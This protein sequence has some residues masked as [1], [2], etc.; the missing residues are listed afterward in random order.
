[1]FATLSIAMAAAYLGHIQFCIVPKWVKERRN[2]QKS[3]RFRKDSITFSIFSINF[4][5]AWQVSFTYIDLC[6]FL[7]LYPWS[8]NHISVSHLPND[9]FIARWPFYY[10]T[11][12]NARQIQCYI[13]PFLQRRPHLLTDA[14]LHC[15][16]TVTLSPFADRCTATLH[17]RRIAVHLR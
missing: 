8:T 10:D 15:I 2:K 11:I 17:F 4:T 1:M 16:S 3:E 7:Q 5:S 14:T 13:A 12:H 6:W 9:A